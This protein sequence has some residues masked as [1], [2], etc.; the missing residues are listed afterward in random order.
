MSPTHAINDQ[1]DVLLHDVCALSVGYTTRSAAETVVTFTGGFG[2]SGDEL[3]VLTAFFFL[4][5]LHS[6]AS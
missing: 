1:L 4:M 2:S 5:R 6:R 3:D